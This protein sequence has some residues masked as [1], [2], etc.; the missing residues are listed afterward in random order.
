MYYKFDNNP[1]DYFSSAWCELSLTKRIQFYHH[2]NYTE[3]KLCSL[4]PTT[5]SL[6]YLQ[7]GN[8]YSSKQKFGFKQLN[9][10]CT[11][12]KLGEDAPSK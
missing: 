1:K 8:D 5:H 7:L 2:I 9:F 6:N 3:I 4:P 11:S 12:S 10:N